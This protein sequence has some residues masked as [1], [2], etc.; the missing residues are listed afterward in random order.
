MAASSTRSR[1]RLFEAASELFSSAA[2]AMQ[3]HGGAADRYR[4]LKRCFA[5]SGRRLRAI[6]ARADASL[7][8]A[9]ASGAQAVASALPAIASVSSARDLAVHAATLAEGLER[10]SDSF[11]AG[12]RSLRLLPSAPAGR[13]HVTPTALRRRING[14]VGVAH[15]SSVELAYA[16][17]SAALALREAAG[18]ELPS[19]RRQFELP[20]L[21]EAGCTGCAAARVR[22]GGALSPADSDRLPRMNRKQLLRFVGQLDETSALTANHLALLAGLFALLVPASALIPCPDECQPAGVVRVAPS[23]LYVRKANN[24]YY[25]S[26]GFRW[27]VCCPCNCY[28]V[29]TQH[30][31]ETTE[32][33]GQVLV[34][35]P[36][37]TRSAAMDVARQRAA[38]LATAY[39]GSLSA[40]TPFTSPSDL[41]PA[42]APP[43]CSCQVL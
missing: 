43:R 4:A 21:A 2:D 3:N 17:H 15:G 24:R 22:V 8:E 40:G 18:L 19:A 9:I 29:F 36:Q 42:L 35:A 11:L 7:T 10:L 34:L 33:W 38:A 30:R 20:T 31:L 28:L 5:G 32:W 14:R 6:D 27:Q 41:Q 13:R 12:A 37:T 39:N 16:Y 1:S 25:P 26:L 23:L